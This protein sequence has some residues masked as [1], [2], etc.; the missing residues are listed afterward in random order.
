M[1]QILAE[2]GSRSL[3]HSRPEFDFT[4]WRATSNNITSAGAVDREFVNMYGAPIVSQFQPIWFQLD[5]DWVAIGFHCPLWGQERSW[6]VGSQ[7]CESLIVS[8][9][10]VHWK[11]IAFGSDWH[12]HKNKSSKSCT[13]ALACVVAPRPLPTSA[14]AHHTKVTLDL[15]SSEVTRIPARSAFLQ[16]VTRATGVVGGAKRWQDPGLGPPIPLWTH[17]GPESP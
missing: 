13:F 2:K 1:Y 17:Q 10:I 12:K 15:A 7:N 9:V 4:V 3:E 16:L 6:L 14:P 5:P 8:K 11:H